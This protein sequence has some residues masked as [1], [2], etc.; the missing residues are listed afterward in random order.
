MYFGLQ[1]LFKKPAW[2]TIWLFKLLASWTC[3]SLFYFSWSWKSL[4]SSFPK[5]TFSQWMNKTPAG[6]LGSTGLSATDYFY[7]FGKGINKSFKIGLP[8]MALCSCCLVES[9]LGDLACDCSFPNSWE[10]ETWLAYSCSSCQ[11]RPADLVS[12]GGCHTHSLLK[13]QRHKNKTLRS[14]YQSR[15]WGWGSFLN[16]LTIEFSQHKIYNSEKMF[17]HIS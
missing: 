14:S 15:G 17:P 10:E 7:V 6:L 3:K 11:V 9:A 13:L 8:Q 1:W 12:F 5:L 16:R 4:S 2:T